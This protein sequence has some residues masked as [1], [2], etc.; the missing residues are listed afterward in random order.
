[1]CVNTHNM[2]RALFRGTAAERDNN[3]KLFIVGAAISQ[4]SEI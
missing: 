3:V 1:M 4:I 2:I